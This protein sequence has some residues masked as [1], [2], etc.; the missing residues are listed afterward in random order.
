VTSGSIDAFFNK[1]PEKKI[2][3]FFGVMTIMKT[4]IGSGILGLSYAIS[5]FSLIVGITIFVA[6]YM[7]TQY[8]C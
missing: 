2:N 7:A 5:Q 6:I 1:E 4:I 8:T 3:N